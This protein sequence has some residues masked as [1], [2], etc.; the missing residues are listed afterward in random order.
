VEHDLAYKPQIGR[1][2]EEEFEI[3]DELNG[4]VLSGEIALE[5]LQKA[6]KHRIANMEQQFNNHYELAALIREKI[7]HE[8]LNEFFMGRV[9]VLLRFLHKVEM[10]NPQ[11][12]CKYLSNLKNI[13]KNKAYKTIADYFADMVLY[14]NPEFYRQYIE[15]K[16][17]ENYVGSVK[18]SKKTDNVQDAHEAIRPTSIKRTPESVKPY[19]TSDEYKLYTMIYIRALAYLMKDAKTENTTIILD[20]NNYQFKATG[21]VIL[22]DGYLKVYA[23]YEDTEEAILPPLENYKSNVIAS[24]DITK[25]QHFT[26]PPARYTE[27]KLIKEMEELGIGRPS[28][29]AK[30]MDTLKTRGYADMVEKKFV[31][32]EIG[33]EITDKLQEFFKH[34]INVKYTAQMEENLDE[35]ADG[36]LSWVN[37]LK[38]FYVEF[39]PAVKEAFSNMEKK[40]PEETGETCPN[41]GSPLVIRKGKYGAFTACSNYP[42]CKYVKS[43]PKTVVEIMKCPNCD[44][45]IVERKSKKG[46]IFYGCNNYPKCQTAYWDKPIDRLCPKFNEMLVMTKAHKIKCS[47]CDYTE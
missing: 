1:L 5:R 34:L 7:D 41:C 44:G 30:T 6:F 17:G 37:T 38:D 31:P 26:K 3:L 47:K 32:T 25:E 36:K 9:D 24:N 40:A 33:I 18:K 14:D 45:M 43:E 21:Q 4:L 28:T 11:K 19:L 8:L 10:D 16:Y 12:I 46:K 22:F 20:N 39:E 2:S 29:Y 23:P 35:I 13:G 15:A 27:A 42:T